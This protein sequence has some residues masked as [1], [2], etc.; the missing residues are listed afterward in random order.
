[1]V[2]E[3]TSRALAAY[4]A[5]LPVQ[6]IVA[7]VLAIEGTPYAAARYEQDGQPRMCC[8][9]PRPRCV[10]R[11]RA[12]A[13]RFHGDEHDWYIAGY[14]PRE[15]LAPSNEQFHPFGVNFLLAA[16]DVPSGEPIDKHHYW[17]GEHKP[18]T[19]VDATFASFSQ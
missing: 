13:F 4:L 16:W 1:M 17:R 11:R 18:Y 2:I 15:N 7:G 9:G 10:M 8:V 19:R 12:T 14:M 6:N 3:D 5:S